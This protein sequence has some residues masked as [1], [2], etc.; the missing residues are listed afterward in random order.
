MGDMDPAGPRGGGEGVLVGENRAPW[1]SDDTDVCCFFDRFFRPFLLS[2]D[3]DTDRWT[4][5]FD[6]DP[7]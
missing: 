7:E 4:L 5:L 3:T 1:E 6:P 2:G